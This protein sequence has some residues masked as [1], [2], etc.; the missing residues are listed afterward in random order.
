MHHSQKVQE[1]CGFDTG[2]LRVGACGAEFNTR[3]FNDYVNVVCKVKVGVNYGWILR[4]IQ[5]LQPLIFYIAL[6]KS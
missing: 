2:D 4:L 3:G 1:Q 6:F 5:P